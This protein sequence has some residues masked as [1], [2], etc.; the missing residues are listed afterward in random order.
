MILLLILFQS[1]IDLNNASPDEI[2]K[3]PISKESIENI[4]EYRR[5]YGYFRSVYDLLRAVKPDE[6]K[7]IKY[8]VIIRKPEEIK[9]IPYYIERI[10]Q[11][12]A[13][14]ERPSEVFMDEW[15][16][17]AINPMNINK[18]EIEDVL[19]L[20]RVN[21]V[22]AISVMRYIRRWGKIRYPSDMR[23]SPGLT[24]YGYRNIRDFVITQEPVKPPAT[25]GYTRLY[26]SWWSR[27]DMEDVGLP[28]LE[29][30]VDYINAFLNDISADTL[31]AYERISA[32]GW[33]AQE[34][35]DLKSKLKSEADDIEAMRYLRKTYLK[36]RLLYKQHIDMGVMAMEMPDGSFF[37]KGFIGIKKW[38][39]IDALYL[40][41]YH[42]GIGEGVMMENT[43]DIL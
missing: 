10:Q 33:T 14:E 21:L 29:E 9:D 12:L 13:S 19:L 36:T 37:P 15:Q 40:G 7:K 6:F 41:N 23:A 8:M 11:R 5:E 16:M 42:V 2:K 25:V 28:N 3:L 17:L 4:L 22:D 32:S 26:S 27:R 24:S 39:I 34:I 18:A 38:G 31:T 43:D 1:P 30:T 20:D 35:E